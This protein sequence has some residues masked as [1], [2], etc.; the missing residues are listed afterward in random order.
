MEAAVSKLSKPKPPQT[1][2][3]P[4]GTWRHKF[5]YLADR[6]L[7][8]VDGLSVHHPRHG[9][10]PASVPF[11]SATPIEEGDRAPPPPPPRRRVAATPRPRRESIRGDESGGRRLLRR[12]SRRIEEGDRAPPPPPPP[13]RRVAATPR[14]RRGSIRDESGG[15]PRLVSSK[16]RVVA[17]AAPPLS[18][19]NYP[20]GT[21][22]GAATTPSPRNYPAD[23]YS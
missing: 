4:G 17:A 8:A 15:S 9:A 2:S 14:P 12:P 10:P 22:G 3:T 19:R 21:R 7:D 6:L 13:R 18:P 11:P 1:V 5:H 20:R 16:A 23:A